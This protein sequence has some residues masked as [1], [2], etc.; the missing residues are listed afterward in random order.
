MNYKLCERTNI[1]H[2]Y[3]TRRP[4]QPMESLAISRSCLFM[5]SLAHSHMKKVQCVCVC[6][7][8]RYFVEW[9]NGYHVFR[10]ATFYF[11][12]ISF[13]SIFSRCVHTHT[14]F[15]M[16][17]GSSTNCVLYGILHHWISGF[18]HSFF[19]SLS[20]SFSS[21]LLG[22]RAMRL[23]SEIFLFNAFFRSFPNFCFWLSGH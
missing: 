21:P 3:S 23:G 18:S 14:K 15:A 17:L 19:H 11:T 9:W 22:G 2:F 5:G 12:I 8:R 4:S 16:R 7:R 10:G 6:R 20:R 13:L 1:L